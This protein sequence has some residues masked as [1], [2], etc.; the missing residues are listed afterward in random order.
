MPMT[1]KEFKQCL[2]LYGAEL[3]NWPQEI[4]AEARR[5]QHLAPYSNLM[6]EQ[7]Y[8]DEMLL[9]NRPFE[10]ASSNLAYRIINAAA[11]V[12][13]A[14]DV[15]LT[16]WLQ[17]FLAFILPKPAFALATVL[18]LGIVIGFAIPALPPGGDTLSQNYFEDEGA[19]L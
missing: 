9:N 8:F 14:P 4:A 15:T 19:I 7:R 18:T 12:R 3:E 11:V 2:L 13:R 1:E 16:E 17:E 10:A 5:M 6:I